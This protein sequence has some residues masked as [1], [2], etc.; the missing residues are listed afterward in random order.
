M[1]D[2]VSKPV[3]DPKFA[4]AL[5][6]GAKAMFPIAWVDAMIAGPAV[7]IQEG[8]PAGE[9]MKAL[10]ENMVRHAEEIVKDSAIGAGLQNVP[11]NDENFANAK[12]LGD[13]WG[14]YY[15]SITGT[16]APVW[17]TTIAGLA[18]IVGLSPLSPEFKSVVKKMRTATETG[19]KAT[20][21]GAQKVAR[22]AADIAKGARADYVDFL[23]GKMDKAAYITKHG[24]AQWKAIENVA[25]EINKESAIYG[26]KATDP[27]Y[28]SQR[29]FGTQ[30]P[31][32]IKPAE[33]TAKQTKLTIEEIGLKKGVKPEVKAPK[34]KPTVAE[35][36]AKDIIKKIPII[37]Q[38]ASDY[39]DRVTK[40]QGR[41]LDNRELWKGYQSTHKEKV[42]DEKFNEIWLEKNVKE[43]E[44]IKSE[45][46]RLSILKQ[47]KKPEVSVP[48]EQEAKK[49]K[50]AEEFVEK[51]TKDL[52]TFLKTQIPEIKS[53]KENVITTQ[54]GNEIEFIV[55]TRGEHIEISHIFA[56]KKG[57]GIGT[58]LVKAT[59]A[60]ADLKLKSMS[61]LK[62]Y[63]EPFWKKLGVDVGDGTFGI[64]DIEVKNAKK[65]K[66]QL[67]DIYNK[68]HAET[69]QAKTVKPIIARM[70]EDISA[71]V[72]GKRIK[73]EE[74]KTMG[75]SST[76]PEYFKN[77]GYTKKKTLA[78]IDKVIEGKDLTEK[79]KVIYDDLIDG[80]TKSVNE[81]E[82]QAKKEY[83]RI[84]KEEENATIPIPKR[85]IKQAEKDAQKEVDNLSDEQLL[86]EY[87]KQGKR[88]R[89][90]F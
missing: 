72:A 66:Q 54:D 21:K 18:Q 45:E 26:A 30:R 1:L 36:G 20:V 63:N 82:L 9:V 43:D 49:F 27:E 38:E 55:D 67:T 61:V 73:T 35:A 78:I 59:S 32:I 89:Y 79:Q 88:N 80:A 57:T 76:F 75:I 90:L 24:K 52:N 74:G 81:E 44:T 5:G 14:N 46:K 40:T 16:E 83:D 4:T 77:K 8:K 17:Y 51:K 33:A 31:T 12:S 47:E 25:K 53:I 29:L 58:K 37:E 71:G 28:V 3:T 56:E 48:L 19:A 11:L 22:G 62:P 34:V 60:F 15:E 70:R 68:A 39:I 23:K 13:V 10:P 65:T 64:R 41:L 2:I 84:V 69:T 85:T 86:E 87:I 6:A 7:A 50:T 42:S